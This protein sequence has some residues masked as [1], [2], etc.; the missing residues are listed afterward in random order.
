MTDLEIDLERKVVRGRREV[1]GGF[2]ILEA[3][4][5][6]VVSIKTASNEP[7]FMD[8][9]I[10]EDAFKH[11]NVTVWTCEDIGADEGYIGL[12]GSPTIVTGLEQAAIRERKREFLTGTRDE[13]VRRLVDVVRDYL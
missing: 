4:M 3:P 5:P 6:A 1:R 11:A 7:R 8:Y 10:K 2:E 9:E 12:V 13:V